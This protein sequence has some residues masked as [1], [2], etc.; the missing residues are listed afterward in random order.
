MHEMINWALAFRTR[1]RPKGNR[2]GIVTLSGGAG[3]LMADAAPA[4]GLTLPVVPASQQS[5]L[6]SII[7]AFGATSNPVDCTGQ[8]VNDFAMFREVL[9]TVVECDEFDTVVLAGLPDEVKE[10]W[11]EAVDLVAGINDKPVF[12]WCGGGAWLDVLREMSIPALS[13]PAEVMEAIGALTRFATYRSSDGQNRVIDAYRQREARRMLQAVRSPSG[14][15]PGPVAS[16]V[17]RMYGIAVP[18]ETAVENETVAIRAA[19]E[20]GYPVALKLMSHDMP[21]KSEHGGVVLGIADEWH[22]R[23]AVGEL[24]KLARDS[25]P[26]ETAHQIMVQKMVS[27]AIEVVCGMQRD[28]E[29]GPF[30]S[31]GMG[32]TLVEIISE[33][34]V[35]PAPLDHDRA[36][37][38]IAR[39]FG[40]RLVTNARGLTVKQ[41]SEIAAVLVALGE[42]EL[43]LDEVTEID[44]N[45]VIVNAE[46]VHA[47]DI[48]MICDQLIGDPVL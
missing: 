47:V 25:N 34:S 30:I 6:A 20:M 45:P 48:L 24:F 14:I 37:D 11:L 7:P 43:E 31:V 41:Q 23:A 4:A 19:Q 29:Y 44:L 40:G 36:M 21:H 32:G 3:I 33:V 38:T 1:R 42:I 2:V 27:G 18:I 46:H 22:L 5:H 26:S 28:S 13:D 17:L 15:V 16:S 12:V 8:V 39:L 9:R 35:S 10:N